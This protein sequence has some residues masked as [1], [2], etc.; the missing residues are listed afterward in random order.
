VFKTI[1]A[2]CAGGV[3]VALTAGTLLLLRGAAVQPAGKLETF[4]MTAAKQ[5][6]LVGNRNARNP[7][8][9]DSKSILEGQQN[10]SH[11][12]YVCHGSDGQGTGVPFADA[13]S[14]PLPSLASRSVQAY[15]DGQLFWVIKNGLWP[16]GMPR[17]NGILNDDEIWSIVVYIR[18]LPPAGSLPDPRAYAD[19]PCDKSSGQ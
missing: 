9:A 11:Y 17:A 6:L 1:I 13:M 5:R 12:C 3:L 16:T 18:H 7:V 2:M 4:A 14:P 8:P 19:E 15:S 10:F